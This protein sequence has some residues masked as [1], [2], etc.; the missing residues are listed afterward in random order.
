[1]ATGLQATSK[2]ARANK[3]PTLKTGNSNVHHKTVI[4]RGNSGPHKTGVDKVSKGLRKTGM[5]KINS[6]HHKIVKA[7]GHSNLTSPLA[8]GRASQTGSHKDHP[9]IVGTNPT[10][11]NKDL[12]ITKKK[13]SK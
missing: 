1:M 5:D 8:A 11:P 7:R 3:E 6:A 4:C 10:G 2:E 13:N 12:I 9:K